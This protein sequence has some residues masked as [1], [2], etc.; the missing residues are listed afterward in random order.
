MSIFQLLIKYY[1]HYLINNGDSTS[2]AQWLRHRA[3]NARIEGS[4]PS[5]CII[6]LLEKW[7]DFRSGSIIQ[8]KITS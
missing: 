8:L 3:Y 6:P 5:G 2:V 7:I 1:H 4:N